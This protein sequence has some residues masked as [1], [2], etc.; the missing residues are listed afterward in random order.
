MN[1]ESNNASEP[2]QEPTD[3]SNSLLQPYFKDNQEMN[4]PGNDS[5][6]QWRGNNTIS[7]SRLLSQ[8]LKFRNQHV[9]ESAG[10]SRKRHMTEM[11]ASEQVDSGEQ[12]AI[13]RDRFNELYDSM[14]NLGPYMSQ[15]IDPTQK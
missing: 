15:V 14:E 8:R 11:E 2:S 3:P 4:N 6:F 5:V 7:A 1:Q 12:S 13:A 9:A 10:A